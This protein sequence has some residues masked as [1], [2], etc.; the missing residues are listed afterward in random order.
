MAE[1]ICKVVHQKYGE[2]D[3]FQTKNK[4]R[5]YAKCSHLG[6]LPFQTKAAQ[7]ELCD[8]VAKSLNLP[9]PGIDVSQPDQPVDERFS[10]VEV[11]DNPKPETLEKKDSAFFDF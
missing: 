1:F 11:V 3:V 10:V 2:L 5:Y 7:K 8:L 9:L 6:H 4:A